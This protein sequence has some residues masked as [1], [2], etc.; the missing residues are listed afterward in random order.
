MKTS[1]TKK[2]KEKWPGRQKKSLGGRN[3]QS[4]EVPGDIVLPG[5]VN[6]ML[7][8]R[9]KHPIQDEFTGMQLF[10]DIDL[11]LSRLRNLG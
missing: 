6:E 2:K 3:E 1:E 7:S 8:M 5:W 11:F 4:V 9:P 10:A